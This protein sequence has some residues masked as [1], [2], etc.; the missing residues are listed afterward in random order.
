MKQITDKQ[1]IKHSGLY[2]IT[3]KEIQIGDRIR[4]YPC[5]ATKA[6]NDGCIWDGTVTF[7][8]GVFTVSI[9]DPKQVQN[10]KEWKQRYDWIK[11]RWWS[12]TV[13]YGE[14]GTWDCPRAPLTKIQKGFGSGQEN[15]EK[16]YKP[17]ADKI[18]WEKRI[19]NVKIVRGQNEDKTNQ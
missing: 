15:F 3:G 2:D 7:E 16:F 11:S 18:G 19:L 8:D 14:W 1:I 5:K 6:S 10:P 13:G 4:F 17:L 9:S 12:T